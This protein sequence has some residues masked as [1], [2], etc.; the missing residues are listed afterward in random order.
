MEK[1]IFIFIFAF[2]LLGILYLYGLVLDLKIPQNNIVNNNLKK[3]TKSL[4]VNNNSNTIFSSPKI[5]KPTFQ[6]STEFR[7]NNK[8]I[9]ISNVDIYDD[10]L[11]NDKKYYFDRELYI[12]FDYELP[13]DEYFYFSIVIDAI[14]NTKHNIVFNDNIT[15]RK[16]K[17]NLNDNPLQFTIPSNE[18]DTGDLLISRIRILVNNMKNEIIYNIIIPINILIQ[19]T[20]SIKNNSI[21]NNSIE[22]F[23][24]KYNLYINV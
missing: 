8:K 3:N 4:M 22:S 5:I 16:G 24:G 23:D 19:H 7:N 14:E 20:D 1:H 10:L 12:T 9:I 2:L 11:V 18:N 21:K 15:L 6:F 17:G 13:I